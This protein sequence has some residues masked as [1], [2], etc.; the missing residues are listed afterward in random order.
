[1]ASKASSLLPRGVAS[2]LDRNGLPKGSDPRRNSDSDIIRRAKQSLEQIQ[3]PGMPNAFSMPDLTVDTTI[4][5]NNMIIIRDT[6]QVLKAISDHLDEMIGVDFQKPDMSKMVSADLLEVSQSFDDWLEQ[7]KKAIESLKILDLSNLGLKNFP[8]SL[9]KLTGLT[10]L[11][12]SNNKFET[13][14]AN[15]ATMMSLTNLDL[16]DNKIKKLPFWIGYF[17]KLEVLHLSNNELGTLPKEIIGLTNLT[18]IDLW[19]N[20]FEKVPEVLYKIKKEPGNGKKL[21]VCMMREHQRGPW[22]IESRE[23]ELEKAP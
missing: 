16:S 13:L 2:S 21:D 4:P 17:T 9:N 5:P 22:P 6:I 8:K 12:L 1:M 3:A 18:Q 20:K 7:N 15:I 14:S 10:H 19:G 11:D 23:K